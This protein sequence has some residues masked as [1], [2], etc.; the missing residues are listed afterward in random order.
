MQFELFLTLAFLTSRSFNTVPH[1]ELSKQIVKSPIYVNSLIPQ[2]TPWHFYFAF[3]E[4][5]ENNPKR[6]TPRALTQARDI[7]SEELEERARR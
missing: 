4:E 2:F 1:P 7:I 5:G 6:L 3:Q